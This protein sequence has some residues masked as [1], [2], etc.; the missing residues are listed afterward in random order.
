MRL[1][2]LCLSLSS[3]GLYYSVIS[4]DYARKRGVPAL[5]DT[6]HGFPHLSGVGSLIIKDAI[7]FGAA[8][9]T[10]ADSAKTYLRRA[11]FDWLSLGLCCHAWPLEFGV[12]AY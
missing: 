3:H 8:V 6:T 10:M 5:G 2:A 9:T 1:T 11:H 12:D 4:C 7:M